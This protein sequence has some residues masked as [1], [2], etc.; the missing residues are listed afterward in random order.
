MSADTVW[1]ILGGR[2]QRYSLVTQA[3]VREAAEVLG[4]RRNAG[5]LAISTGRFRCLAMVTSTSGDRSLWNAELF[6]GLERRLRGEGYHLAM[7]CLA[8]DQMQDSSMAK[9]LTERS[10]DGL[11]LNYVHQ[12]PP[13]AEAA[14][15]RHRLPAVWINRKLPSACCYP[16]DLAAGH[17]ATLALIALGHRRI[18]YLSSHPTPHTSDADRACGYAR[19]M[20]AAGLPVRTEMSPDSADKRDAWMRRLR[21]L[22]SSKNR[23]TAL[24]AYGP[25]A[26][27]PVLRV[28]QELGLR[29]PED[30][31]LATFA[32]G[33]ACECGPLL[34]TWLIPIEAL[35]ATIAELALAAVAGAATPARILPFAGVVGATHAPPP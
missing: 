2:G 12:V 29:I 17:D 25:F 5:A 30:L 16:D 10:A 35:G 32:T 26:A 21:A 33:V 9:F 22:L 24:V 31:S 1:Q 19:A 20:T 14:I 18:A 15:A 13:E 8:D 27:Y 3:R 6:D 4:Y 7:A 34:T 23:P 11:I 28:A